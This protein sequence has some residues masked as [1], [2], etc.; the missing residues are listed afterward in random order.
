MPI[1]YKNWTPEEEARLKELVSLK[2]YSYRQIGALMDR[3]INSI[4][5]HAR[6]YLDVSNAHYSQRKWHHKQDFFKVPDVTNSYIAGFWAAD[7][8]IRQTKE[9]YRIRLE[10]STEDGVHLEWIKNTLGHQ[11]PLLQWGEKRTKFFEMYISNEYAHQMR[12]NFGLIPNKTYRLA[13]PNLSSFELRFAYLLGLLDGDGCVHL[14]NRDKLMLSYASSSLVAVQWVQD[15][16]AS[17]NLPQIK[18]KSPFKI[19]DLRPR[20]NAYSFAQT[21]ARTVAL[22]QLAQHFSRLHNLPILAR[23]WDNERLNSYIAS[24]YA[25]FPDYCFDP[26]DKL[27]QLTQS[28]ST[29]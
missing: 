20:A 9:S 17:M 7:G 8:N 2:Q 6:Q 25:R 12:E 11:A 23:K 4:T 29:C 27:A 28:S 21:G 22:I 14:N 13:P 10:I 26:V 18:K 5:S 15:I 16:L 24:F 3:S 19:K 1:P